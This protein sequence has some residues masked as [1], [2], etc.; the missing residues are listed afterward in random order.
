MS[1]WTLSA[2]ADQ[3]TAH[4]RGSAMRTN[5]AAVALAG[6]CRFGACARVA[7]SVRPPRDRLALDLRSHFHVQPH[8]RRPVR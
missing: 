2:A 1:R 4:L 7:F 5:V 8:R 3:T 6:F